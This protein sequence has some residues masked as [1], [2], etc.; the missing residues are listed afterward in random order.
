MKL[1]RSLRAASVLAAPLLILAALMF[2]PFGCGGGGGA[3]TPTP[4]PRQGNLEVG[5][6]DAPSAL[7]QNLLL[8]VAAVRLN[9]D[10]NAT[11]AST[12]WVT[13]SVP[14]GVPNSTAATT[15]TSIAGGG[16][17]GEGLFVIG[18]PRT[19]LQ[20]DL[21]LTQNQ[22]Q[23]FNIAHVPA[24]TYRKIVLVLDPNIPGNVVPNCS[25]VPA[26]ITEGCI[27]YGMSFVQ[28]S[29]SPLAVLTPVPVSKGGL[30]TL[31]IDFNPGVPSPPS[32]NT[33]SYT[34]S[35]S[36]SVVPN[37]A[38]QVNELMG[39]VS[40]TVGGS[41]ATQEKVTAELSG[42]STVVATA[43]VVNHN[44]SFQLPASASP[45]GTNYDVYAWGS[46][47]SYDVASA[48]TVSRGIAASPLSFE[49]TT[50]FT[51]SVSGT[52]SDAC[53]KAVIPGA[54]LAIVESAS[55][56]NCSA[57][58]TPSDCVVV[59]T[60][61]TDE[62]GVYPMPGN[63]A[64]EP[65]FNAVP[66]ANNGTY[67][68]R[69]SASGYQTITTPL[70]VTNSGTV[71]CPDSPDGKTCSFVLGTTY[72]AGTVQLGSPVPPGTAANIQ[73]FAEEAGTNNLVS[74]LPAPLSVPCST[75][76]CTMP[77]TLNV[78][79]AG[80]YDLYATTIDLFQG[81]PD[82]FTGHTMAVASNVPASAVCP[83]PK[84]PSVALGPLECAG[85]GSVT[86]AAA[87]SFDEGT[88]VR[89]S[90]DGVDLMESGVGPTGTP[91]AGQFSFCAPADTYTLTRY[92]NGLPDPSSSPT[93]VV[94]PPPPL[95][96]SPC[97]TTCSNSSGS[98]PGN[99]SNTPLANPL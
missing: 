74:A 95:Q 99:C 68:L 53:T 1:L 37:N 17:L 41:V 73:V 20:I 93:T 7:F 55:S 98:C 27:S 66:V 63:L 44:F 34:F 56:K 15:S 16:F 82:P 18:A 43:Q 24:E 64:A 38:S 86:G 32:S 58:P 60:A 8:N 97:P 77:F 57:S 65:P 9:P 40:G 61:S 31:V 42:T 50:K 71:T 94:L 6:V 91:N 79:S 81:S 89:L 4:I 35:P 83:A 33:G 11:D 70:D 76:P 3:F 92:E 48:V 22:V 69:I 45:S 96:T 87:F 12:G 52:I 21:N 49:V 85:H 36:I 80:N 28:A 5:F 46:D 2:I 62:R 54:T 39:L 72:I 75:A 26:P 25:K 59:A 29:P 23:L 13:V 19:E 90:K 84:T 78:P 10:P 30:T 47:T 88:T 67:A 51:G 14:G